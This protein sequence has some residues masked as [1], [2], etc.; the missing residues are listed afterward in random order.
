MECKNCGAML[1]EGQLVCPCCEEPI[2]QKSKWSKKKIIKLVVAIVAGLLVLSLVAGIVVLAL[3]PKDIYFKDK[4][5]T[6]DF[7]ANAAHDQVVVT[8][9]DYTLTNGQ[10]QVFYWMQVYDLINYYIEQYGNYAIYYLGIDLTQPLSEQ[11]YDKETGMTWEQYF[12][13]DAIFAWHRYQ[14]LT[15]EA[16]KAG[17]ALPE[18]Y[19]KSFAEMRTTMEASAK[20]E[21]YD[22]VDAM[23]QADLGSSVTF[24]DYYAYME[25]YYTGNLYFN[26][27]TSKMEFSDEELEDFYKEYEKTLAQY[28]INKESGLLV[29]F[30]NILV[31]PEASKDADGKTVY[32][33]AAWE[34][35]LQKAKTIQD[36]WEIGEKT[37]E[38]FEA[39]AK[40]KSEDK[41]SAENGGLYQYVGKNDWATV[42][43][44]HILIM[45][46]GGTKDENGSTIYSDEEWEACR[47]KAQA[48]LDQYLS[49]A[50]TEDAFGLLANEHSQDKNGKVTDGGLYADV[51]VGQMVDPFEDW[52]FD[53]ARTPG[54]TGLVKTQYG[55]H[56]MYFVGRNGP[57]DEWL[58]SGDRKVGDT[59]MVKTDDGY[60]ILYYAAEEEA[61]EVWCRRGL[62]NETSQ[63]LM[64][65][66]AD[67]RPIDVRYW[68]IMLSAR[69]TTE[70]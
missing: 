9:G 19:Q 2:P 15:D 56:V 58:F 28:D 17:Y 55:Y 10:L 3:R 59:T 61:W 13:E 46:E 7:W 16:Q 43:V 62:L 24:D 64:E 42:D 49:G 48:I 47:V 20:K 27:L 30:H 37:K 18:E 33:E 22:S 8:M 45:P 63:E 69:V 41:T 57:V 38:S 25:V 39:L 52:I 44:R 21:G 35:C 29:D 31:K 11:I 1:E 5:L 60:Q 68:A 23:L 66:F 6:S 36:T 26:E 40:L 12:L 4:Y 50:K 67:S 70:S 32:T 53:T 54:E 34:A 65:S 51:E 14:A